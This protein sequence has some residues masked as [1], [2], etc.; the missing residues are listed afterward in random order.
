VSPEFRVP[1]IP[2]DALAVATG[3][4]FIIP[5][6][7]V[8]RFGAKIA[9]IAGLAYGGGAAFS[10]TAWINSQLKYNKDIVDAINARLAQLRDKNCHWQAIT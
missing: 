1:G 5:G 6:A 8:A 10:E 4:L 3:A 9:T 2:R 7:G